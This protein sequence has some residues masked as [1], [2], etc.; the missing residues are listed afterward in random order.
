MNEKQMVIQLHLQDVG[1]SKNVFARIYKY[2]TGSGN[3]D[4]YA[5]FKY[6]QE[7]WKIKIIEL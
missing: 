1:Q 5:D 4:V 7:N 3:S 6:K 2:L